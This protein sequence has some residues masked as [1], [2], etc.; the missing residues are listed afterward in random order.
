M[1]FECPGSTCGGGGERSGG[2]FN[3]QVCGGYKCCGT[4]WTDCTSSEERARRHFYD[5]STTCPEVVPESISDDARMDGKRGT[6]GPDSCSNDECWCMSKG[7]N[8]CTNQGAPDPTKCGNDECWDASECPGN[9]YATGA[10]LECPGRG[11]ASP[12]SSSSSSSSFL[13][14]RPKLQHPCPVAGAKSGGMI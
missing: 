13:L 14:P 2:G 1:I 11:R 7:G 9:G 8:T 10:S 12:S 4:T 3:G 6:S 5:C